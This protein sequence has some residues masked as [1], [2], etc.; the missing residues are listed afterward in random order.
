MVH[1]KVHSD[2]RAYSSNPLNIE[3]KELCERLLSNTSYFTSLEL[4]NHLKQGKTILP[5]VFD[6]VRN[7]SHFIETSVIFVKFEVES[8]SFDSILNDV[9]S[10]HF[11]LNNASFIVYGFDSSP[12]FKSFTLG[13]VLDSPIKKMSHLKMVVSFLSNLFPDSSNDSLYCSFVGFGGQDIQEINFNNYLD[14]KSLFNPDFLPSEEKTTVVKKTKNMK[15][16]YSNFNPQYNA[17]QVTSL[18]ISHDCE[19]YKNYL[20]NHTSINLKNDREIVMKRDIV[21]FFNA[22]PTRELFGLYVDSPSSYFPCVLTEDNLNSARVFKEKNSNI[23]EYCIRIKDDYVKLTNFEVLANLLDTEDV[24]F[25]IDFIISCFDLEITVPEHLRIV[26]EN[27]NKLE[28]LFDNPEYMKDT[29]PKFYKMLFKNKNFIVNYLKHLSQF[30][31]VFN[32][33]SLEKYQYF[34]AK[35]NSTIAKVIMNSERVATANKIMKLL[36][37][38]AYLG[39]IKKIPVANY[40][41]EIKVLL[42]AVKKQLNVAKTN[43]VVLLTMNSDFE[44]FM[45]EVENKCSFLYENGYSFQTFTKQ[46]L[47]RIENEIVSD[48]VYVQYKNNNLDG[49]DKFFISCKNII[50]LELSSTDTLYL[51]DRY[52]KDKLRNYHS[53]AEVEIYYLPALK[54]IFNLPEFSNLER[55]KASKHLKEL[56][57]LDENISR[58]TYIIF[59]K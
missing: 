34:M 52:I 6:G 16:F 18:I 20:Q 27:V 44:D 21:V 30:P 12:D 54:K 32:E 42:L 33:D 26:K 31:M 55:K 3:F 17:N 57:N 43:N 7:A 19:G 22:I 36:N 8:S 29:Y 35:S 24:D 10:N 23:Y 56:L 15:D 38:L 51:L 9:S 39:F 58:S 50:N 49:L 14:W 28:N 1:F 47:N 46:Y 37:V 40:P 41:K 11:V 4:A 5:S 2:D 48:K 59:K 45:Q 13:F 53:K 25:L